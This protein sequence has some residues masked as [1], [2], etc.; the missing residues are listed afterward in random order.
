MWNL[1]FAVVIPLIESEFHK[2]FV[3]STSFHSIVVKESPFFINNKPQIMKID[4]VKNKMYSIYIE[5]YSLQN[6][7]DTLYRKDSYY[8]DDVLVNLNFKSKDGITKQNFLKILK[9]EYMIK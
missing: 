4:S 5:Q 9:K 8:I 6:I 1:I 7:L 2:P 3:E